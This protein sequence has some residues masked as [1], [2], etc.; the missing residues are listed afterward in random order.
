MASSSGTRCAPSPRFLAACA[1]GVVHED[2]AHH[3]RGDAEEMRAVPP[4]DLALFDQPQVRLVNQRRRLERV[5]RPLAA[6]LA[7]ER[8][9]ATPRRR[10]AAGDRGRVGRRGSSHRAAP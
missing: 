7:R 2:S 5:P 6:K 9:A 8:S 10:A 3:L 1:A 4:V